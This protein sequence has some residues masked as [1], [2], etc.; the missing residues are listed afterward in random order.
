MIDVNSKIRPKISKDMRVVF[1]GALQLSIDPYDLEVT[2]GGGLVE[3]R[4]SEIMVRQI[5]ANGIWIRNAL[6]SANHYW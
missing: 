4:E 5:M 6:T 2:N 1:S 3:G